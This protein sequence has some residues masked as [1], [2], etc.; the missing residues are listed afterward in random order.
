ME[1]LS[2]SF[3]KINRLSVSTIP[4]IRGETVWTPLITTYVEIAGIWRYRI[5]TF[6]IKTMTIH[7]IFVNA[8][9][10][11]ITQTSEYYI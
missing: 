4:I 8:L 5:N 10:F 11:Y 7:V 1:S 6:Q 3:S 9:N 2:N